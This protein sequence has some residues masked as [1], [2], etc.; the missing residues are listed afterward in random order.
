M[1][2]VAINLSMMDRE[3]GAFESLIN[4]AFQLTGTDNTYSHQKEA[5]DFMIQRESGPIPP[6]FSLWHPV[7]S[8]NHTQ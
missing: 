3:P 2:D 5:L 7:E 8:D 6:E 4:L 1:T